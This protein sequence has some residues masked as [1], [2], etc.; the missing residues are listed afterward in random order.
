M[1]WLMIIYWVF[2]NV[3]STSFTNS[4]VIVR[5]DSSEPTELDTAY[6]GFETLSIELNP[7]ILTAGVTLNQDTTTSGN[8]CFFG[9][10]DSAQ[11]IQRRQFPSSES[12][13]SDHGQIEEPGISA[14]ILVSLE[15]G[16]LKP[17]DEMA[18]GE[19]CTAPQ[20]GEPPGVRRLPGS[21]GIVEFF[22]DHAPV[23]QTGSPP[24]DQEEFPCPEAIF[25]FRSTPVC[26]SGRESDILV[27]SITDG[28]IDY[29]LLRVTM[30]I[31][32]TY[33]HVEW[34]PCPEAVHPDLCG[35]C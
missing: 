23:P 30:P 14:P 7:D 2:I 34:F 9:S 21:N 32:G 6:S 33:I 27:Q 12:K 4:I 24:P 5:T 3:L 31:L 8:D 29:E 19:S 22:R 10:L 26:D 16:P 20:A 1:R 15:S 28:D 25:H 35:F 11:Q 17:E 18:G 13:L